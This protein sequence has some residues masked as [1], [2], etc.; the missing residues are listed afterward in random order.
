MEKTLLKY[1]RVETLNK[2]CANVTHT[3]LQYDQLQFLGDVA[4]VCDDS[5]TFEGHVMFKDSVTK[6]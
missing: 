3:R 2:Q 6:T 5:R 1:F 4:H